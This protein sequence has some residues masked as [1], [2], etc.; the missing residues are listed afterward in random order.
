MQGDDGER[1]RAFLFIPLHRLQGQLGRPFDIVQF[2]LALQRFPNCSDQSPRVRTRV[3]AQPAPASNSIRNDY[4]ILRHEQR[5]LSA[6]PHLIRMRR[7][8]PAYFKL[9]PLLAQVAADKK[10][11]LPVLAVHYIQI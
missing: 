6:L 3:N 5:I 4:D 7:A 2:L 8:T 1:G 9:V 10:N 11:L